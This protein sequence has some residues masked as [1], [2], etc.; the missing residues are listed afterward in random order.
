MKYKFTVSY[1]HNSFIKA[2]PA[3]HENHPDFRA[4]TANT[5]YLLEYGADVPMDQAERNLR[6]SLEADDCHVLSIQGVQVG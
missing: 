6:L 2:H 1:I 3:M 4:A 5:E